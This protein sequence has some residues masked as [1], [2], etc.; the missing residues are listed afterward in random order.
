MSNPLPAAPHRI[1]LTER[2][3]DLFS[4]FVNVS[5]FD[6]N[7]ACESKDSSSLNETFEHGFRR[8]ASPISVRYITMKA[9]LKNRPH[10]FL[11]PFSNLGS[12]TKVSPADK[13][14][15][16]VHLKQLGI[17]KI[18]YIPKCCCTCT[19]ISQPRVRHQTW[20]RRSRAADLT[21]KMS[22]KQSTKNNL[23][24][25]WRLWINLLHQAVAY[26]ILFQRHF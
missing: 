7:V 20:L 3:C 18:D 26:L 21:S 15:S 16:F 9:F 5:S 12:L 19:S 23:A 22:R 10:Y 14:N 24:V 1:S 25:H 8:P 17:N 2:D 13:S 4:D 11:F 6:A